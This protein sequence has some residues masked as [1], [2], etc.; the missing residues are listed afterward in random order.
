MAFRAAYLAPSYF[1][2][3]HLSRVY[4]LLSA[5]SHRLVKK[6]GE[7]CWSPIAK[8]L[9]EA[10]EKTE[11]QGRIGKQC[12]EVCVIVIVFSEPPA[13]HP[14]ASEQSSSWTPSLTQ[15]PLPPPSCAQRWNHHLRP[16]IKKEAWNADE[17]AALVEA[18]KELG[19]KWSDIARLLPGPPPSPGP[20]P[21]P[22]PPPAFPPPTHACMHAQHA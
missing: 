11:D 14:T 17:E 1:F 6:F 12:R 13:V 20:H 8:A 5:V 18:H 16:D 10:F 2:Q 19:N 22:A 7:G 3:H 21:R 4:V 9:N 15:P